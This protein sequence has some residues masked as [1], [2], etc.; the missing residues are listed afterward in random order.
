MRTEFQWLDIDMTSG[1]PLSENPSGQQVPGSNVG[2]V[3]IIRLYGCTNN[4]NS[5]LA[6]VHGFTPYFYVLMPQSI[7]IHDESLS[8]IRSSLDQKVFF[9]IIQTYF[10]NNITK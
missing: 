3:P 5:V 10:I 6:H 4:G 9:F 2:P 8:V 1:I 7:D